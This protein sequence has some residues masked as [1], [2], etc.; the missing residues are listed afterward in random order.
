MDY[1][2]RYVAV[3]FKMSEDGI[4]LTENVP[5]IIAIREALVNLL[6]HR[7]YFDNGQAAIRIY[8]DRII[9]RNPGAA[10]FPNK[11]ILSGCKSVP[12]NPNIA[13]VFRLP[14]WAEIA[15]SGMMKIF[16]NWR[17]AG[18]VPPVI[19]NNEPVHWFTFEFSE[20]VPR[21]DYEA[22]SLAKTT[23]KTTQKQRKMTGIILLLLQDNPAL[24]IP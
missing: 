1:L 24:P 17:A 4:S 5:Q 10:P 14:G 19:K 11:Q 8:R 20:K 23:R 13:R 9:F 7:D 22:V 21:L 6:V 16:D 3:S 2:K 12:R 15:G 18:Y